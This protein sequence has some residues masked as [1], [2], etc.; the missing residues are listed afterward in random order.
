MKGSRILITSKP[1]GVFEQVKIVGTPKPGTVME[2]DAAVEPVAN[3]FSYQCYGTTA[4]SGG[5]HVSADGDRKVIAVLLEKNDEGMIYSQAYT[6]GDLGTIYYPL[7]GEQLNMLFQ[8]VAGTGDTQ[9]IGDEFMV[10][11]G[12]GKLLAC[13]SDA[14][15]QPFTC[16]ETMAAGTADKWIQCRFNGSGG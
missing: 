15:S 8:D 9:A 10:D 16:L 4:A 2:I 11:D 14:E 13:D 5:N 6:A 3:V 7:P 12:T 1:R